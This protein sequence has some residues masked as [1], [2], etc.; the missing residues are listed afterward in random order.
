MKITMNSR[1]LESKLQNLA[2]MD[3]GYQI[4]RTMVARGLNI[5]KPLAQATSPTVGS[6]I[7]AGP[8]ELTGAKITGSFGT[9]SEIGAYVEYG[10]GLPGYQGKVSNGERRNPKAAGFSYTLK[11]VVKSGPF[12]GQIRDGWVYYKGR[13]IHTL[14][15]PAKPYMYPAQLILEK[16][17]AGIAGATVRDAIRR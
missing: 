6:S 16:D 17:A 1:K 15:Q 8:I 14:G 12:A 7:S 9:N 13:F 5:A 11:T 3:L 4:V 2:G 10:T